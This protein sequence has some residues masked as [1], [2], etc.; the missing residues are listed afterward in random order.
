[1]RSRVLFFWMLS[2]PG[3]DVTAAGGAGGIGLEICGEV[4]GGKG[5]GGSGELEESDGLGPWGKL[6]GGRLGIAMF[7]C[8]GPDPGSD[9]GGRDGGAP[10][11]N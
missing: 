1:M 4:E 8:P 3:T 11:G 10:V 9:G 5:L 2:D 7:L 6:G